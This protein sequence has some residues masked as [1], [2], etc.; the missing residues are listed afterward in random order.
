MK[1]LSP[2]MERIVFGSI[3]R[4]SVWKLSRIKSDARMIGAANDFPGIT[5]IENMTTP[6]QCFESDPHVAGSC[7]FAKL[8]KIGCCAIDAPKRQRRDIRADQHQVGTNSRMTSNFR[9]ARSKARAAMGLWQSLEVAEWLKQG[10]LEPRVA[11]HGAYVTRRPSKG[12]KVGLEIS[13][14]SKPASAM[15]SSFSARSPLI[16]TVAIEVFTGSCPANTIRTS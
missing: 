1:I 16:D 6:G 12:E 8:V 5:V 13:T 4:A 14:P 9:R 11:H 15:A 10:D 3:L 7:D 2:G